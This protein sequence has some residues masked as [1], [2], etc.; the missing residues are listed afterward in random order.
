MLTKEQYFSIEDFPNYI[1]YTDGDIYSVRKCRWLKPQRNHKGYC[2]VTL[3]GKRGIKRFHIARLIA[4]IFIRNPKKGEQINH[5]NGI[6]DDNRI[7]NLEW[8]T[9]KENMLHANSNG[10]IKNFKRMLLF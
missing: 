8:V 6:K 9:Y 3:Y 5:K 2:W 4:T 1:F 10:L 7:G